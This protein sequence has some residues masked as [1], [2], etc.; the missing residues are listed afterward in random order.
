MLIIP[1]I[2]LVGGRCVRLL[3]GDYDLQTTYSEDPIGQALEFE[4]AGFRRL[5]IVDLEGAKDGLGRNREAI[6]KIIRAVKA[7][8]QIGG[9]I[10]RSEDVEKLL[11][12]G[13][14]YL[15]LATVALKQP[16]AVS[17][18]IGR[19]GAEPFIVSLDVRGGRLRGEGWLVESRVSVDDMVAR[20]SAWGIRQV[21][22]TDIER[23]GTLDHPN[24]ETYST[25][26][27]RLAEGTTLI[28]AGGVSSLGQI[29]ELKRRGVGG[30]IVGKA[31]YEGRISLEELAHAC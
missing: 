26:G 23:D 2:D 22:C 16:E 14:R 4:A 18:W 11:S 29:Q 5:H 24:Y 28:A 1:A 12:W 9:G 20:L 31:I 6:R 30:A 8:V 27:A 15:I 3:K 19:W 21:I 25:L 7:P 13:A 10:R 17:E